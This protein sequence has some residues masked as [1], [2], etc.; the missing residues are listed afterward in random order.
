[1]SLRDA[2]AGTTV[3]FSATAGGDGFSATGGG[4][5]KGIEI[6]RPLTIHAA[7]QMTHVSLEEISDEEWDLTFRT[8]IHSIFYLSKAA[9]PHMKAGS[10]IVNT[11]SINSKS[12]S[13]SKENSAILDCQQGAAP[14]AIGQPR[15]E[16][17]SG[18]CRRATRSADRS[19]RSAHRV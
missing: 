10:T 17:Q 9:V 5:G 6:S 11:A 8:N 19:D 14:V 18:R 1:V 12:P 16:V 13:I 15:P 7:Y 2:E 4:V 3:G